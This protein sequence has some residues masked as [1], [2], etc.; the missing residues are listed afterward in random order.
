MSPNLRQAK[1]LPIHFQ[2]LMSVL[3]LFRMKYDTLEA[4]DEPRWV[5]FD[6]VAQSHTAE[7][8]QQLLPRL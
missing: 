1:Y 2:A 7:A 8:L 6:T 4:F 3:G 5:G